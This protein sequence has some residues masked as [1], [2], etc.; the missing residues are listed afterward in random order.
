MPVNP[1]V[2]FADLTN[3]KGAGVVLLVRLDPQPVEQQLV[4]D[5]VHGLCIQVARETFT[6][7]ID[8][9]IIVIA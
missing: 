6:P 5:R 4:R 9:V 7:W 3:T 8:L 2:G 1:S